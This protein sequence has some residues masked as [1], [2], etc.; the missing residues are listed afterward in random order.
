M[1]ADAAQAYEMVN[2]SQQVVLRH[3]IVDGKLIK[4][5]ALRFLLWFQSR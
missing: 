5:C 3:M 4:E 1:L 2:G